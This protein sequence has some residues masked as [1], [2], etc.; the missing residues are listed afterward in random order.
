MNHA[1]REIEAHQVY[2]G[3]EGCEKVNQGKADTNSVSVI[4]SVFH[5][6]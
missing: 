6:L 5:S 1:S 3:F 2:I 4:S